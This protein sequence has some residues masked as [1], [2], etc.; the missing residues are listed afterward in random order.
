MLELHNGVPWAGAVL[1]PLNVRLSAEEL[2]Y[3]LRHCGARLLVA[4]GQLAGIAAEVPPPVVIQLVGA[5]GPTD[6]Y[7][8]LLPDAEPLARPCEDELV[9][10]ALNYTSG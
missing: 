3:I 7:E 6:E 2:Q 8:Q 10:L 4:D 9:L 1:V 5:G